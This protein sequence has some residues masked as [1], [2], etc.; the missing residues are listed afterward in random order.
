MIEAAQ[1]FFVEEFERI[2]KYQIKMK[3]GKGGLK[4][5]YSY[6]AYAEDA[7][8]TALREINDGV[9]EGRPAEEIKLKV[10]DTLEE[11]KQMVKKKTEEIPISQDFPQM[12]LDDPKEMAE[13]LKIHKEIGIASLATLSGKAGYKWKNELP[14]IM[15]EF[16]HSMKMK[17]EEMDTVAEHTPDPPAPG[18]STQK[19]KKVNDKLKGEKSGQKK[20]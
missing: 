2:F 5:E 17:G 19:P 18:G 7:V 1:Y 3:I 8:L 13:V 4:E 16:E 9:L 15:Q 14:K 6:P 11:G 12:M 10:G 20:K